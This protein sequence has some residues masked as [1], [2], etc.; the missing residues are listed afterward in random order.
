MRALD[1]CLPPP[2]TL[3]RSEAPQPKS[4]T[5]TLPAELPPTALLPL[6]PT[7][8]PRAIDAIYNNSYFAHQRA[9][10][11]PYMGNARLRHYGHILPQG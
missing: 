5:I 9:T 11:L 6:E 3:S 1:D 7:F 4:L 2:L 10:K 8:R